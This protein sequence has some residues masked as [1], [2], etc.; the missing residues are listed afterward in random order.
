VILGLFAD[1]ITQ[2]AANNFSLRD[3]PP[4]PVQPAF[5]TPYPEIN[6]LLQSVLS[7]A[8]EVLGERFVGMVLHGSLASGGF[9]PQR[10]DIDFLI[11]TRKDLPEE[12][13]AGLRNMHAGITAGSMPWADHIE[14]S[15]I[16]LEALRRYDPA[17][18][19]HPALRVD[20]SL[21][22]DGHG[23]DWVIQRHI[24]RE[25]GIVLAGLPVRDLIDPVSPNELRRAQLGIL[26]EWWTPPFANP[27]RFNT[28]EYQ[29]YSVLTM[30]RALYL[31]E[32][33]EVAT[34]AD[35]AAWAQ[36]KFGEHWV[37][38]IGWAVEW[39]RGIQAQRLEETLAFIDFTLDLFGI[40]RVESR[41]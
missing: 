12:T 37:G 31:L 27:E 41:K 22:V 21:D 2:S 4:M 7:G 8:R 30:C 33:G 11:I 15:Y 20:G 26:R 23:P 32:N 10:S 29:A 35:A 1:K 3:Q 6:T 40:R 16:P 19:A 5:P 14:G 36:G 28:A 34:K 38:L 17:H 39:R 13:I 18:S 9:D 24:I 25:K